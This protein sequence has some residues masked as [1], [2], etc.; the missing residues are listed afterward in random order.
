MFTGRSPTDDMFKDSLDLHK[1][2]EAALPNRALEIADPAIWLHEEAKEKDPA[3]ACAATV[4]SR[5]EGCLASVIGLAV[6]CSK[7]QPMERMAIR[8][9]AVEM[10]SIRDANLMVAASSLDGNLEK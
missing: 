4:R 1:Y 9:A 7:Q 10:R 8:D 6:S 5:S 3:P 2:A